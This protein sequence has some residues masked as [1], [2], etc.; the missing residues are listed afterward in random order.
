MAWWETSSFRFVNGVLHLGASPAAALVRR[1]GTPLY[2]YGRTR[3][4]ENYRTIAAAFEGRTASEV[5]ICYAMKANPH[6]RILGLL[7]A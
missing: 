4:A 2:V 1:H 3:I 7:R 6:P 5:R